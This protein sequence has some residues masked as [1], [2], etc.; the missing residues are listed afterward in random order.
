MTEKG[1]FMYKILLITILT[2]S[3]SACSLTPPKPPSCQG[4]FQPINLPKE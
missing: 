3:V 1:I 2:L 4:E